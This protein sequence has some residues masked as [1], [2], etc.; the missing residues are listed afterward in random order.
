MSYSPWPSTER[1]AP[2]ILLPEYPVYVISKGR[3]ER[4]LTAK[5]LRHDG[6]PFRLVVEPQER[7]LYLKHGALESEL[8][9][10]PFSNLGQGSIPV[11]NFVWEHALAAGAVR[12]WILDDNISDFWRR[13]QSRKIRCAAGPALRVPEVFVDRYT[14]IGIAG[15][16]YYMFNPNRVAFPPFFLNVHVYS[17]LLIRNDLPQRWRGRY[18]EDTDLCLQVLSSGLCTVLF[19]SFLAWK[20]TTMTMKGGNMTDLY[21]GDGRLKM[22]RSLERQWPGVVETKRRFQR[23]QHVVKGAWRG[24]DTPLQRRTD[25][26]WDALPK[27]DEMG[28]QMH[29]RQE[30]KNE[31]IRELIADVAIPVGPAKAAREGGSDGAR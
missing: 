1:H 23:P 29:M 25:I 2:S 13:W 15:L 6:V 27:V 12:H 16:N 4:C 14:N 30:P 17:C 9:V 28:L 21:Q 20:M 3:A 8:L 7:D 11:R 22:A 19:N 18:N 31:R 5:V 24:F 10:T 26:D